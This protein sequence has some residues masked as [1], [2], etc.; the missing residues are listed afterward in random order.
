M[1]NFACVTNVLTNNGKI[2]FDAQCFKNKLK[3]YGVYSF[4][5]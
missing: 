1:L 4:S 2:S 3:M 5:T